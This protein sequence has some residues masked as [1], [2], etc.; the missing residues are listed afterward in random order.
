MYIEMLQFNMKQKIGILVDVMRQLADN[1]SE[2]TADYTKSKPLVG[3]VGEIYCRMDDYV[4][5][6]LIRRIE[7]YGG[8]VWLWLNVR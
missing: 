6:N 2:I 5:A 4:N 1:F 8:E 7:K 3:I